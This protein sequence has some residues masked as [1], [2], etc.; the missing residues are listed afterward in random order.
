MSSDII[1][2]PDEYIEAVAQFDLYPKEGFAAFLSAML[3]VANEGGEC[4]GIPKKM[5]RGDSGGLNLTPEV[6]VKADSEIGDVLWYIG[7]YCRVRGTTFEALMR[8]NYDKLADRAARG[9]L[10]GSGDER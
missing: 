6:F 1:S 8:G 2:T 4:A 7:K 9:V 10:Q 3:G 5:L